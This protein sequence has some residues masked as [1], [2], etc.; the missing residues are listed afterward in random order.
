MGVSNNQAL[1]MKARIDELT[2]LLKEE[3]QKRIAIQAQAE[4]EVKLVSSAW[5]VSERERERECV[6]V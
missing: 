4:R 1:E 2:A 5:W 3:E 6:C